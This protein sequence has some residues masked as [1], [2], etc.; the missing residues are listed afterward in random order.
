MT[1]RRGE[2]RDEDYEVVAESTMV[3][4]RDNLDC[5]SAGVPLPVAAGVLIPSTSGI[6][7]IGENIIN[8]HENQSRSL[9]VAQPPFAFNAKLPVTDNDCQRNINVG[10]TSMDPRPPHSIFPGR[11]FAGSFIKRR[12]IHSPLK[13][14]IDDQLFSCLGSTDF[15]IPSLVFLDKEF[16]PPLPPLPASP[17]LDL[18]VS[19][20]PSR[21]CRSI[22]VSSALHPSLPPHA[23]ISEVEITAEIGQIIGFDVNKDD[24]ILMETLGE[25]GAQ[26]NP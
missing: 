26:L 16:S 1:W 18:N 17:S 21:S 11:N 25:T 10:G 12:M 7:G 20:R 23:P 24:E 5:Q 9:G 22:P 2:I 4:D 14:Q 15:V 6:G 8:D 19:P 13:D 3:G